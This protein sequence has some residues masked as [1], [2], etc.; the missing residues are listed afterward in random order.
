M[1]H[2]REPIDGPRIV[3]ALVPPQLVRLVASLVGNPT[4]CRGSTSRRVRMATSLRK[5]TLSVVFVEPKMSRTVG[6]AQLKGWSGSPC[7]LQ[8]VRAH[9]GTGSSTI[10]TFTTFRIAVANTSHHIA[11]CR[12]GSCRGLVA[13]G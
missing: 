8:A 3:L 9:A 5:V 13:G 7:G 2:F 10:L 6:L 4:S 12:R 1:I 11:A